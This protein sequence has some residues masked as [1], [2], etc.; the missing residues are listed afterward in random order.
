MGG[1]LERGAVGGSQATRPSAAPTRSSG[2]TCERAVYLDDEADVLFRW[3]RGR[4][5]PRK[6]A[7]V[8]VA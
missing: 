8:S 5:A 1:G 3:R 6:N 2:N 4:R 7:A